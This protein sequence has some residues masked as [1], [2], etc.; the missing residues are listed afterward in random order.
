MQHNIALLAIWQADMQIY[1]FMRLCSASRSSKGDAD[2][3]DCCSN[4][5]KRSKW[6]AAGS[7][8]RLSVGTEDL[9]EFRVALQT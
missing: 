4:D 8:G 1:E 3:S 5:S 7:S 2:R 9:R 6:K